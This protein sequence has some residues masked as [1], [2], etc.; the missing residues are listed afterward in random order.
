MVDRVNVR[1]DHG[2]RL[3]ICARND[4]QGCVE[5]VRLQPDRDEALA[6]LPCGNE[7]LAAHMAALLRAWFLVLDVDAGR[8]VLDEH[9]GQLHRRREAAM[10]CVRI[11]DD[12]VH[13][14]HRRLL[15]ALLRAHPPPLLVLLAVMEE[16]RTEEL[17]Y[18][19]GH[20]VVRI[21]SHIRARLV[22]RGSRRA[23][24]PTAHIHR[25]QVLGHLRHLN[26]VQS[27]EG[28]RAR[29]V[30]LVLSQ[31]LVQLLGQL[32]AGE[33]K[34]HR[35]LKLHHVL[36]LVGPLRILEPLAVHPCAHGFDTLLEQ[37]VLPRGA[38]ATHFDATAH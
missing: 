8:T 29:T 5:D 31:H 13:V 22:R 33:V 10:A 1:I 14:V 38:G 23:A 35:A 21:V 9:L 27:A 15:R 17:V 34:R 19:V 32:R 4:D 6:M 16:L 28:V 36:G 20:G 30:R 11:G 25:G 26:R 3:G 7:D 24:L 37:R 12:R 2:R 18:L